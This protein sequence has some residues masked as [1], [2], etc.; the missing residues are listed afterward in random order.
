MDI[1]EIAIVG[2]TEIATMIETD[3]IAIMIVAGVID[4]IETIVVA[5]DPPTEEGVIGT[6][7]ERIV[8]ATET[9]AVGVA[10]VVAV[11]AVDRGEHLDC[12]YLV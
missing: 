11:V 7:I 1:T 2:M 5:R 10:V 9:M 8:T 4:L 12:E 6:M 3:V